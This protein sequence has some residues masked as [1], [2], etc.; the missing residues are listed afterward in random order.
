M[1]WSNIHP[2]F[3]LN[4]VAVSKKT[5]IELS[6]SLIKE[7]EVFEKEIGDFL[8]QWV[9]NKDSIVVETSGSTGIPKSIKLK[10]EYMVNSAKATRDF[11]DLKPKDSALLCMSPNYIAGKMML[12]RAMVL[13][14]HLTAVA[15][16]SKPLGG[17]SKTFDFC[18]MVPMQLQNSLG[19]IEKIKTVIIGGAPMSNQLKEKVQD[20]QTQ[21]FETYGM[22]ETITHIALKNINNSSESEFYALPGVILSK[23]NRDCLVINAPKI[24][25][26]PVV[27]NDIIELLSET[28]FNWLG[29]YDSIINSGG[30]KLIPEQIEEKIAGIIKQ[31]FFVAGV[32]DE[33]L[34]QKMVLIIEGKIDSLKVLE[35]IKVLENIEKNQI[36]KEVYTV[37]Y[38]VYTPNE[39]INR[40]ATLQSLNL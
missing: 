33:V 38:F 12:V 24:A 29:R 7:G 32:P 27:T 5:I 35:K 6:Y 34:G 21:V 19:E 39:K 15:A 1:D 28:K 37:P 40:K 18:A 4:G 8:Q 20:I 26:A 23:D 31:R 16:S 13:G 2:D 36:P 9:D 25:D 22:T 3:R 14:L 17:L 11:F 10:K 30:I